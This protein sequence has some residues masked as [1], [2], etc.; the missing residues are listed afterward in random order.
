MQDAYL[1]SDR[2]GIEKEN[3]DR[4]WRIPVAVTSPSATFLRLTSEHIHEGAINDA[5]LRMV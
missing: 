3:Q 4:I 1:S 5:N 2:V